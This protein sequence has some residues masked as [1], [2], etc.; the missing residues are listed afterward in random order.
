MLDLKIPPLVVF[1]IAVVSM[2]ALSGFHFSAA[3][4]SLALSYAIWLP[5]ALIAVSAVFS[6]SQLKTTVNPHKPGKA[7][8]L[9][10]SGVFKYTRN[11]MYLALTMI[12]IG[13]LF[14]LDTFLAVLP[15]VCF[16]CY[17]SQFQIKPEEA[18]LRK[19]FGEEYLA[20]CA[21]VRR[22]L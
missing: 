8:S 2:L 9:V 19:K 1:A 16:V 13:S 14:W 10:V 5:A 4:W 20:Y 7:S 18:I 17:L 6:F 22:W 11:P 12:L 15:I 21:R 3:G